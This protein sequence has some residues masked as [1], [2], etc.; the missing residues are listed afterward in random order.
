VT[1]DPPFH[2]DATLEVVIAASRPYLSAVQRPSAVVPRGTRDLLA[3][4][5]GSARLVGLLVGALAFVVAL[6]RQPYTILRPQFV[7]EETR[8]FWVPTFTL[9]ALRYLVDST[10]GYLVIVPR[11]AFLLARLGSP[12]VAPAVTIAVH[13]AI[14]ALVAGFFA[15]DRL[16]RAIPDRRVRVGFALAIPLLA[17]QEVFISVLSAQWFLALYLVGL[18]LTTEVRRYDYIGVAIAGL[19]GIGAVLTLPLFWRDRRGL[20]LLACAGVQALVVLGSDR[21]PVAPD[22]LAPLGRIGLGIIPIVLAITLVRAL[23]LRTVL[24]F[25]YL[26]A[27]T[28]AAGTLAGGH[29]LADPAM[30]GRFFFATSALAALLAVAG[31]VARCRTAALLGGALIVAALFSFSIPAPPDVDWADHAHCIGGPAACVVPAYPPNLSVTWPG[32]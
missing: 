21:R 13:A 18:S 25:A 23:P 8:D 16:A 5:S 20:V 2:R 26:A 31:V 30:G 6:I 22:L 28:A 24:A 10:A 27:A 7:W 32:R 3:R 17:V 15:S 11:V 4:W 1:G 19:S 12:E 9:D 29:L 14:I